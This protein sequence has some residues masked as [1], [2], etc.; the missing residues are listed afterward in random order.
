MISEALNNK[1]VWILLALAGGFILFKIFTRK[2][3][4]ALELEKEYNE[5]LDSDKYRVKGQYE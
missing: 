2:D 4:D 3:Q 1:F 5:I